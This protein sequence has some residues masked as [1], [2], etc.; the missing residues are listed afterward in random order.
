MYTLYSL[1][2]SVSLTYE[3]NIPGTGPLGHWG[4][5]SRSNDFQGA[6]PKWI[7]GP[8]GQSSG[9]SGEHQQ[10]ATNLCFSNFRVFPIGFTTTTKK[11]LGKPN[12][13]TTKIT[14]C[15]D[16]G[17]PMFPYFKNPMASIICRW[18]LGSRR[19]CTPAGW[20]LRLPALHRCKKGARQ[21]VRFPAGDGI[22][23]TVS[24]HAS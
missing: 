17:F 20:H 16:L 5:G 13:I 21:P 12:E 22:W 15:Q 1:I 11:P 6:P 24:L 7:T 23:L 19:C 2:I 3:S 4:T 9:T 14:R 10:S 18:K 8:P